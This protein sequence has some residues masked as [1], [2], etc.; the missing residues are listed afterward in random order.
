MKWKGKDFPNKKPKNPEDFKLLIR[1]SMGHLLILLTK[2]ALQWSHIEH[3]GVSIHQ[4]HD[5]LPNRLFRC[6]PKK[7][8]KLRVTGLCEGDSP[9]TGEFP[10]HWASNA[11]NVS[12][13]WRYHEY[14]ICFNKNKLL[15]AESSCQ[16]FETP[17]S[18]CDIVKS[19]VKCTSIAVFSNNLYW[20]VF[21]TLSEG[22]YPKSITMMPHERHGISNHQHLD[23][24]FISLLRL[25]TK[26]VESQHFW[27][28]CEKNPVWKILE[29]TVHGA[30]MGPIWGQQD[31]DGPHVDPM[32]LAIWDVFHSQM[33]QKVCS[34]HD[35]IM[36]WIHVIMDVWYDLLWNVKWPDLFVYLT[37][38]SWEKIE[39]ISKTTFSNAISWMKIDEFLLQ[40]QWSLYPSIEFTIFQ[41]WFR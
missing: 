1:K 14:G 7:T 21:V 16:W 10:A 4:P 3:D 27:P 22:I 31:P 11:E 5:C 18:W 29:S 19:H 23:C 34:C 33:K 6:R 32:N 17:W 20:H 25:T 30:H 38:L 41:H 40:F 37:P 2:K 8:S 24:L 15:N 39:A 13:W 36:K 12:I 35:I 26:N 9:V 28:L